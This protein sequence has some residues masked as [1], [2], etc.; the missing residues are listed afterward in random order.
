[1]KV[2][3]FVTGITVLFRLLFEV[4][5]PPFNLHLKPT[6]AC[7]TVCVCVTGNKEAIMFIT[8][9]CFRHLLIPPSLE[10]RHFCFLSVRGRFSS[11]LLE[12]R[13]LR[14][15]ERDSWFVSFLSKAK[16]KLFWQLLSFVT[17]MFESFARTNCIK[18]VIVY[19]TLASMTVKR[20]EGV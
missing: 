7:N 15:R 9:R 8:Q 4:Y 11:F 19:I 5:L 20:R 1:M 6:P 2:I 10:S 16:A 14:L 12:R 18:N 3:L 17:E 13:F